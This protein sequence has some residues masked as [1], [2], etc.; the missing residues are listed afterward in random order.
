M[1][2][3]NTATAI[4][5][6]DPS[7]SILLVGDE[8]HLPYDRV[9]L[10]KDYLQGKRPRERLF[11]RDRSFYDHLRVNI[12]TGSPAVKLDAKGRNVE[13]ADGRKVSFGRLMLATGVRARPLNV[14][15]ASLRGVHTLRTL[16]DCEMLRASMVG[17]RRA[18]VVGGGFI[19]CEV[20]SI[21]A[22]AGI[23]TT[24]IEAA[25]HPLNVAVDQISGGW[26]ADYFR[27]KG[28][29]VL[30]STQATAIAGRDGAVEGVQLS[31]G[32]TILADVV[33]VGIGT[34]PNAEL[35]ENAGLK[36][37]RGIVVDERLETS[38][39]DIFAGGDV[40]RFFSPIF[41]GHMRVEHFDVAAKHGAVGGTNMAGGLLSFGEL[42]F[43][44][45]FAFDLKLRAYGDFSRKTVSVRRGN[46]A[47]EGGFVQMY[48]HDGKLVGFL[49]VN[50]SF[51][52]IS[53]LRRIIM[54]QTSFN[55]PSM[56]GTPG[57]D[58]GAIAK[59]VWLGRPYD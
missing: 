17:S 20:A 31:T 52:E 1:T 49:S 4:R 7:G 16:D 50:S 6:R 40:A 53:H 46:L 51:E 34:L 19:G 2:G 57:T 38:E 54:S 3:F 39:P 22:S 27:R 35:A 28:V 8:A 25:T 36:V 18:V 15:G 42:P 59:S 11:Y 47:E 55:E 44:Y 29:N 23:P 26:I 5:R 43:F 45:S 37:D 10:S 12:M 33:A 48:F 24:I 32:E 14:L 58:I 41:G 56:F 13:L 9:P 21:F 30:T